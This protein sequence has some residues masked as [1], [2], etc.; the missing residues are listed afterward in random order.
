MRHITRTTL[1]A[2]TVMASATAAQA[3]DIQ[4]WQ[5]IYDTRVEA[6]DQLIEK[7]EA[8]NPDINVEHVT[9]PYADYQTRVVAANMAGNGPDVLQMFYGWTDTFVNGGVLQPLPADRFPAE[10]IEEEFFPIVTAMKR[11]DDYYGLPTAVRS[12]ALFYNKDLFAEAGIEGPPETLD[13]LVDY[14]SRLAVKD[15]G[16]N[17]TTVGL[18][19]EMGGQDHQWWREV[20]LRQFGGAPYSDDGAT[21]TYDDAAGIAATQ[22]Y[23]DLTT[24]HEVG[25]TGFMDEGQAAFRAGRAA[26]TIDG[27]FRLG[28]FR[29]IEGFEWAVAEL[30]ANADGLRSNYA[31]Y[32]ANGIG[33]KAEGEELEAAAKFL[34]Y[35]SSP[36]AMQLWLEV[37]GELP[38]RPEVALTE[39]NLADPIYAP[40]LKGLEYAHTTTFVDE[41]AQRQVTMDMAN[42]VFLDGQSVEDSVAEAAAQ[43]QAILDRAR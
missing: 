19:V 9:F 30:P 11:G 43:E 22:W 35:L 32:F 10:R 34:E 2:A 13:E 4:Y 5:Y 7:F 20:L 29:D 12:L 17:Y 41:Q 40:F 28:S 27:T 36:E 24:V 33:A 18:T 1:L 42:R 31:S 39:A 6:V 14:A 23:T 38:A 16:G 15:S 25:Y 8:A 3:V 37:V 26:M 21:V